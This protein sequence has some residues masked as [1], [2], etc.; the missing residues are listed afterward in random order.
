MSRELAS[1]DHR[2]QGVKLEDQALI[3][4]DGFENLTNYPWDARLLDH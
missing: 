3:T 2:E 1:A 4:E